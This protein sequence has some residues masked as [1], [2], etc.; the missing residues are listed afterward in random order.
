MSDGDTEVKAVDWC[1]CFA[2][3]RRK[4]MGEVLGLTGDGRSGGTSASPV[5]RRGGVAAE[6]L[7]AWHT[8][9]AG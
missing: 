2:S 3:T 4:Q 9:A 8:M 6:E 7:A 5:D 1:F